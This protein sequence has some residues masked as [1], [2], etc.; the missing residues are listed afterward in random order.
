MKKLRLSK[1]TI[2]SL[3]QEETHQVVGA[4]P[5]TVICPRTVVACPTP[6]IFTCFTRFCPTTFCPPPQTL[7][8][9]SLACPSLACTGGGTGPIGF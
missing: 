2:V 9:P 1:E 7:G 3:N 4:A 6:T 5:Y 8:C